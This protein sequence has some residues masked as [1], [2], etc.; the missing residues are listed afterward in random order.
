MFIVIALLTWLILKYTMLG[1]GIYAIG[2][3]VEAAERAGLNVSRIKF[4]VYCYA[5]I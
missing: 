1:R 2:G 5:G 4:F 3:D